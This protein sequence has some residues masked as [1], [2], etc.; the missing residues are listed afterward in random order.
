MP[1]ATK[2][3]LRLNWT[4]SN[5]A[6]FSFEAGIEG[7]LNTLD[8]HVQLFEFLPG[9]GRVQHRPSGRPGRR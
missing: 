1:S 7:A 3:I 8:H 5:L 9:G 2:R 6:G 4:R